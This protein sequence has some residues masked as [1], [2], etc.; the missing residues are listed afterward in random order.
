MKQE[1]VNDPAFINKMKGRVIAIIPAFNEELTIAMV[2][3]LTAKYVSQVLVVDDG[4]SDRTAEIAS[5]AG[6]EVIRHETNKGKATA[7]KTGLQK[8]K[9]LGY[10]FVVMLDADGQHNPDE[11]PAVIYPVFCNSADMVIGS[12]YLNST[13]ITPVYRRI[14][15]KTIDFATNFGNTVKISDT[16]SGFRALN[17]SR[18]DFDSF[19]ST[20]YNL[21]SDMILFFK[22]RNLRMMEVPITVRYDV[23]YKHKKNPVY[24]GLDII[25]HIIGL[26]SYRRPLLT[27]G[28]PGTLFVIVGFISGGYVFQRLVYEGVYH[29][30][31]SMAVVLF[32][33]LGLLLI[34]TALILNSI[35]KI[36]EIEL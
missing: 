8:A 35:I 27:F 19:R 10:P 31:L 2:V 1:R 11:I 9:E 22:E 4:S 18:F 16:Q 12:R 3:H 20:G 14:G 34:T 13:T 26:I 24:H 17:I 6:S 28:V 21:E 29:Y 30:I 23:P 5:L 7:L 15:Q 32:M 36:V 25:M 33:V